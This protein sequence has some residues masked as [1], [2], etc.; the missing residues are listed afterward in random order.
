VP[1]RDLR[2]LNARNKS[3]LSGAACVFPRA[4]LLISRFPAKTRRAKQMRNIPVDTDRLNLIGTG[5]VSPKAQY[6]TLSDGSSKRTGNQAT[7]DDGMPL[8]VVD[9][10]VDDD[11][12]T[13]S[14]VLGVTVA[15]L[16]EPSVGKLKPVRFRGVSA[17]VFRDQMTGQ[18]KVSLKAEGID[19]GQVKAVQAAS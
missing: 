2:G 7:T 11:D 15:A 17:T 9:C 19:G 6:A 1:L 16:D 12:A 18:A 14:E 5:K 4:Q 8:W 3:R 13:R 10:L